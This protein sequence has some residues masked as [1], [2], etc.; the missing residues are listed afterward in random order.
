MATTTWAI[1]PT[2]TEIGFKVKHMMFTNVSGRFDQFN[3]TVETEGDDFNNA[4]VT[5]QAETASVNTGNTD[6]DNHLK[7]ADFFD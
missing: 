5:F 6:R 3:G 4:N 2:H 1:D 7:S